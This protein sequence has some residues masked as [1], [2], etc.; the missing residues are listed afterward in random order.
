MA[1]TQTRIAL[2]KRDSENQSRSTERNVRTNLL[3]L[4]A[5]PWRVFIAPKKWDRNKELAKAEVCSKPCRQNALQ[6][7]K[8]RTAYTSSLMKAGKKRG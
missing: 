5:I 7:E 1:V 4:P 8:V 3:H 2:E 6:R